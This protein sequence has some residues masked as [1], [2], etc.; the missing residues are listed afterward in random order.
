MQNFGARDATPGEKESNFS[1]KTL[2]NYDTD[3][4]TMC[5][6]AQCV[7]ADQAVCVGIVT[8]HAVLKASKSTLQWTVL[9]TS[10][11]LY[12]YSRQVTLCLAPLRCVCG[13]A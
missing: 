10:A 12:H 3:H 2:G 6:S 8:H 11:D 5:G 7:H 4:L 1:E 13:V 9:Q